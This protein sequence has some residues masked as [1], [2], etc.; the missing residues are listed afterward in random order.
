MEA[1]GEGSTWVISSLGTNITLGC[2]VLKGFITLPAD[3]NT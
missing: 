1:P 3:A 2:E